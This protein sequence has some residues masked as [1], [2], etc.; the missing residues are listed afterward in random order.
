MNDSTIY[1]LCNNIY[2]WALYFDT[3]NCFIHLWLN[4]PVWLNHDLYIPFFLNYKQHLVVLTSCTCL[5]AGKC[6]SGS[7]AFRQWRACPSL[8]CGIDTTLRSLLFIAKVFSTVV[9]GCNTTLLPP[10][11]MFR[12]P[13]FSLT[14]GIISILNCCQPNE[15]E[16]LSHYSFNLHFPH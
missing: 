14:F 8:G 4:A 7:R 9:Y 11:A 16:I 12:C 10:V 2:F 13:T 1:F 3:C 15:Y 6:E 5:P